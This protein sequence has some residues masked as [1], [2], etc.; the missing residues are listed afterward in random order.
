MELYGRAASK[1]YV[2]NQI[3]P[4]DELPLLAR[5]KGLLRIV[6]DTRLLGSTASHLMAGCMG[7]KEDAPEEFERLAA[8]LLAHKTYKGEL[9]RMTIPSNDEVPRRIWRNVVY[10]TGSKSGYQL[11]GIS[12]DSLEL[13][14]RKHLVNEVIPP[15]IVGAAYFRNRNGNLTS[16]IVAA[17][18]LIPGGLRRASPARRRRV[19]LPGWSY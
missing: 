17:D 2:N 7:A 9:A 13:E 15:L 11:E 14:P 4:G 5:G 8:E 12:C 19:L 16:K 6:E 10:M 1:G 18:I 3:V